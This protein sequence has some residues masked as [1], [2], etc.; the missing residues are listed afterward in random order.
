MK[1]YKFKF[2]ALLVAVALMLPNFTGSVAVTRDDGTSITIEEIQNIA[3]LEEPASTAYNDMLHSWVDESNTVVY[4][5]MYGGS[6]LREDYKLVVKLVNNDSTLREAIISVVR[7]P[8]VVVFEATD[9]SRK[10]LIDLTNSPDLLNINGVQ[11]LSVDYEASS[12][13]VTVDKNVISKKKALAFPVDKS[14]I[15]VNFSDPIVKQTAAWAPG[16]TMEIK[17]AE[18][19]LGSVGWFGK[20][21][22][23]DAG[24]KDCLLTAGHV[25]EEARKF[26]P[27]NVISSNSPSS[28][29]IYGGNVRTRGYAYCSFDETPKRNPQDNTTPMYNGDYGFFRTSITQTNQT[30]VSGV[31]IPLSIPS[32]PLGYETLKNK[33]IFKAD[34]KSGACVGE[35]TSSYTIVNDADEGRSIN[36]SYTVMSKNTTRAFSECGDSGCTVFYYEGDTPY[37]AGIIIMG[38]E[39]ISET[40]NAVSAYTT[41]EAITKDDF[42]PYPFN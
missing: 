33:S 42:T 15:T 1:K 3:R 23:P 28:V 32:P 19:I 22:F 39:T 7:N 2:V 14:H 24:V 41:F 40:N 38:P 25:I 35:L 31:A 20:Y 10:E 17:D 29:I 37:V 27:K 30:Y 21:D 18:G 16:S 8:E 34:G 26:Y 6:Y 12:V 11:C 13:C 4:P 9:I 36:N 5:D